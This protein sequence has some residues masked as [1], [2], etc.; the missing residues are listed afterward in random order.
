MVSLGSSLR[1]LVPDSALSFT[2]LEWKATTNIK[3]G[4]SL[5]LPVEK[6]KKKRWWEWVWRFNIERQY[7]DLWLENRPVRA[8]TYTRKEIRQAELLY[9]RAVVENGGFLH[10]PWAFQERTPRG[11]DT[12]ASGYWKQI[13]MLNIFKE[14]NS[15]IEANGST[16]Q[17]QK[18][19]TSPIPVSIPLLP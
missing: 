19:C 14:R 5:L 10:L 1:R 15:R 2:V 18:Y 11:F 8:S 4:F 7:L 9:S 16:F 3:P 17:F 6:E 13:N 12:W